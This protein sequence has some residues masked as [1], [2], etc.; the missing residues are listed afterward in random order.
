LVSKDRQ[1]TRIFYRSIDE[2]ADVYGKVH[3]ATLKKAGW[4]TITITGGPNPRFNG[5]LSMKV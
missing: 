3:Q 5:E 1:L 2:L 4:V